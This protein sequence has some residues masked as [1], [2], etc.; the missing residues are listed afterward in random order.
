MVPLPHRQHE[1]AEDS[2]RAHAGDVVRRLPVAQVIVRQ[3]DR[4]PLRV[5][6]GG[7]A[8]KPDAA[9]V[10]GVAGDDV[11]RRAVA[12]DGDLRPADRDGQRTG[13]AQREL[14]CSHAHLRVNPGAAVEPDV[15]ILGDA[16]G[17]V[18]VLHEVRMAGGVYRGAALVDQVRALGD[19]VDHLRV[20]AGDR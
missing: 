9:A 2:A 19:G 18:L 12:A 16:G 5:R 20:A 7:R 10:L 6:R 13:A 15:E 8:V 14:L 17:V 11:D 3:L 1:E 4:L